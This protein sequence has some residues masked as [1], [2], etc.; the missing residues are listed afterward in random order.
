MDECLDNHY[1]IESFREV[2]DEVEEFVFNHIQELVQLRQ[3]QTDFKILASK[4]AKQNK[5]N[6]KS[7]NKKNSAVWKTERS[8]ALTASQKDEK[9]NKDTY[10]V[11][12]FSLDMVIKMLFSRQH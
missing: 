4:M 6:V 7:S 10:S 2:I 1:T 9:M 3:N 11:I 8:E 5:F 12:I